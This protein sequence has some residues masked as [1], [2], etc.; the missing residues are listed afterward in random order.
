MKRAVLGILRHDVHD[1]S[2]RNGRPVDA[3]EVAI[4]VIA[5]GLTM[6]S[7]AT[8]STVG[9]AAFRVSQQQ[10][11][12]ARALAA[13]HATAHDT[14]RNRSRIRQLYIL[15]RLHVWR[16]DVVVRQVHALR[17]NI[18]SL[19]VFTVAPVDRGF[20]RRSRLHHVIRVV[21]L[22]R[23]ASRR[24]FLV[25]Y[26]THR[27]VPCVRFVL[28]ILIEQQECACSNGRPIVWATE[29]APSAGNAMPSSPAIIA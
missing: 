22:A 28:P 5:F 3:N 4:R 17:R 29:T 6:A 18:I 10:V 14:E 23:V 13:I 19:D 12:A 27:E 8:V 24:C 20:G 11:E 21:V 26:A 15:G 16:E 25:F 7:Q 9:A 1:V 2:H